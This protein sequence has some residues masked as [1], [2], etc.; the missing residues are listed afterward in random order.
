VKLLIDANLSHRVAEL[1]R[2]EGQDAV[3]VRERELA[4]AADEIILALAWTR[5][6]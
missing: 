5:A 1:L 6:G 2:E 4:E 3:H